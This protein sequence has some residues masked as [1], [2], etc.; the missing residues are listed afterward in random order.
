MIEQYNDNKEAHLNT[1]CSMH[2]QSCLCQ[3]KKCKDDVGELM[4][5][6]KDDPIKYSFLEVYMYTSCVADLKFAKILTKRQNNPQKAD[7]G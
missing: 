1:S 2:N 6:P 3:S 7:F 5:I 4:C